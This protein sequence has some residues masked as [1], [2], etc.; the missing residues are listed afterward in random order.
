MIIFI[1]LFWLSG[2]FVSTNCCWLSSTLL[3]SIKGSKL[4]STDDDCELLFAKNIC[5]LFTGSIT[6]KTRSNNKFFLDLSQFKFAF[7][8][9]FLIN[10]FH[11]SF[12]GFLH[13]FTVDG[14]ACHYSNNRRVSSCKTGYFILNYY[15][16][17]ND[18]NFLAGSFVLIL[19]GRL[20]LA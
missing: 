15:N 6:K 12:V 19:L 3:L 8:Y 7:F 5:C 11:L 16:W 10:L 4:E 1:R 14:T 18:A 17:I 2:L 20:T 13:L 9:R